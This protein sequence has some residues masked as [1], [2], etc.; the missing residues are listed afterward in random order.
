MEVHEP[1]SLTCYIPIGNGEVEWQF[2]GHK[3][4]RSIRYKSVLEI[5]RAANWDTG[6]Y[7]CRGR[8][9]DE[10]STTPFSDSATVLVGRK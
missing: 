1:F 6:V 9:R 2:N 4:P 8:Y 10:M 5:S 7:L 3:L